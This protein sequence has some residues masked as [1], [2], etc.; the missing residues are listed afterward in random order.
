MT[1]LAVI[2]LSACEAPLVLDGV[3]RMRANPV[4]RMDRYQSAASHE[5]NVVVVGNQGVI[6]NS[7]DGG[8]SWQRNVLENWPALIDVTSCADGTFAALAYDQKVFVSTDG[9]ASWV[10]KSLNDTTETPQS[11]TCSPNGTLWVVGSFT[12]IWSSPDKGDSWTETSRDEDA[13]LTTVQFFDDNNG[14][15]TGE[16]GTALL[17]KDGGKNW[18]QLPPIPDEF[19]P[20][21]A[22]FNN[23]SEGWL[24]GLGGTILNTSDGG[25]SWQEQP[26]GTQASLFGIERV[27]GQMFAVGGEG[28]M[29]AYNNGEWQPVNHGKPIRLYLRAIE[30][31]DNK[32]CLVGGIG[33]SL[34]VIDTAVIKGESS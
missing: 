34:H 33:G 14:I 21:E 1:L 17:T 27:G 22:Y 20:Q 5:N 29:L 7:A 3:E 24:I 30:A 23:P 15:I 26:S 16:F 31:M 13:I 2:V 6:L 25:N 18:E 4:H 8:N 19:Y 32:R 12:F 11:I 28:T 9:G 10:P